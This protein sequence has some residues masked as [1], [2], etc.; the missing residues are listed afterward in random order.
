MIKHYYAKIETLERHNQLNA[1]TYVLVFARI[2]RLLEQ[3]I[4]IL[5]LTFKKL[6]ALCTS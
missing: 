1:S 3:Y 2:V 6:G 5:T 4:F